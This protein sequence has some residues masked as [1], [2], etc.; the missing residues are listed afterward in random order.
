MNI[1]VKDFE[2]ALLTAMSFSIKEMVTKLLESRKSSSMVMLFYSIYLLLLI[3][4]MV[5]LL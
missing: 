4:K 1:R 5:M 2:V 3:K